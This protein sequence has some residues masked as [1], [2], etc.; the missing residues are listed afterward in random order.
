MGTLG[1]VLPEI[2]CIHVRTG[3]GV[4]ASYEEEDLYSRGIANRH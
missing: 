4:W 2:T 3:L 1:L